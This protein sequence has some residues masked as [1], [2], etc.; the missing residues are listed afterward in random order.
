MQQCPRGRRTRRRRPAPSSTTNAATACGAL[1]LLTTCG[2]GDERGSGDCGGIRAV[3]EALAHRLGIEATAGGRGLRRGHTRVRRTCSHGSCLHR[4]CWP[5]L[6]S[7]KRARRGIPRQAGRD[8][9]GSSGSGGRRRWLLVACGRLSAPLT[10]PMA[11][12]SSTATRFTDRV[13]E[14]DR[15]RGGEEVV[16]ARCCLVGCR[17]RARILRGRKEGASHWSA[18]GPTVRPT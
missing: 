7:V 15:V 3:P 18:T 5:C 9:G 8:K 2:A 16:T 6:G 11:T 12:S 10:R 13:H 1:C 14:G 17:P 4:P